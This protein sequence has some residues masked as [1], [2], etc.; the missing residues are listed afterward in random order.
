MPAPSESRAALPSAEWTR[1]SEVVER[2]E[3]AWRR[4]K[5]PALEDY[6]PPGGSARR[7]ALLE[8]THTDLEYRLKAGEVIGAEDYLE[9]FPELAD[10][11]KAVLSLIVAEDRLL[12]QLGRG[13]PPADYLHR[14]PQ[15]RDELAARLL[16]PTAI[17]SPLA[18]TVPGGH[19]PTTDARSRYPAVPGYQMLEELGRGGMGVVYKARH[20]KLKRLVALKMIRA[21]TGAAAEELARFR[22]EAQAAARLQHPNV[23]Q[24]YEVGEHDGGPYFSLEYVAGGSLADRLRERPLTP[25]KAAELIATL[26][27]AMQE[28]HQHDIVHRD[29][30]P[31]NVLLA[32][33]GTPKIGDF[34]LAKQLDA[35]HKQSVDKLV[36][37]SD[38]FAL[39]KA[40]FD[41]RGNRITE[42]Y[43]NPEV[44]PTLHRSGY[45]KLVTTY[46]RLGQATSL[47][48]FDVSGK[49]LRL[50]V[51]V[52]EVVPG[53]PGQRLGLQVG[54]VLLSYDAQEIRDLVEFMDQRRLENDPNATKKLTIQRAGKTIEC[55]LAPGLLGIRMD[56]RITREGNAPQP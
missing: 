4:G 33:D 40:T 51:F 31:A 32:A 55:S 44:K 18:S 10:D 8:L 30:K 22:T 43:F 14:F 11:R 26:A 50:E 17:H 54:D 49:P 21:G 56:S 6:L 23:V 35:D 28:A 25:R 24:V 29:L 9:R 15:F 19:P 42:E 39:R 53:G 2:F 46:D 13:L 45:H 12:R 16:P 7:A 20:L 5:R 1:L 3:E 48:A 52:T 47:K 34:G 37:N 27:R 41:D 36:A 38:G